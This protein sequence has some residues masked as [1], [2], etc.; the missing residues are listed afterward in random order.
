MPQ[1][2]VQAPPR[3]VPRADGPHLAEI[4]LG[5]RN[6]EA[7]EAL[8]R[9][10]GGVVLPS[11][12][13]GAPGRRLSQTLLGRCCPSCRC[14]RANRDEARIPA[15]APS[16]RTSR[17]A[18]PSRT[19]PL[20]LPSESDEVIRSQVRD[21]SGTPGLDFDLN[22]GIQPIA[23]PVVVGLRAIP[24]QHS[25]R[26]VIAARRAEEHFHHPAECDRCRPARR[27][28]R[29][30]SMLRPPPK[31]AQGIMCCWPLLCC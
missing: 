8:A 23:V 11:R 2:D 25:D 1:P 22:L 15:T 21:V 5:A 29:L 19:S 24:A 14:G 30:I 10:L 27:N 26:D 9:L 16:V 6:V 12:T 31:S 20:E 28:R 3:R 7:H 17:R 18:C 4:K 13:R